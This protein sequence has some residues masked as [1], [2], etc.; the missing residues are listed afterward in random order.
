MTEVTL[1]VSRTETHNVTLSPGE[2]SVTVQVTSSN[3]VTL[4]TTDPS[5]GNVIGT[6]Q[7]KEL[8][9]QIRN[10][11][12]ALLGLQPGVV[13]NNVGTGATNRVGSVTGARTDQTNITID[14]IDANDQATGQAFATVGNAPIDSVQEFRGTTANPTSAQGRSSGGQIELVTNSGTNDFHGSLREYNRTAATAANSF[15]NN[16]AGRYV[17]TDAQVINGQEDGP[18]CIPLGHRSRP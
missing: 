15:F 17:A 10:S 18:C 11:P 16:K 13:G 5:I 2:V 6:R 14:G 9:I 1:G 4:N 8:P 3:D 7:L 12:A